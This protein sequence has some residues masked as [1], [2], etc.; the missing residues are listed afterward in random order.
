LLD[1]HRLL[2]PPL[3]RTNEIN[4]LPH[5][6][7]G[8]R[9]A[10]GWCDAISPLNG[11]RVRAS[12]WA[13]LTAKR[14]PAD[15]VVLAHAG[16]DGDWKIFVIS[17]QVV[18]RRDVADSLGTDE[19]L[20]SGWFA[21]FPRAAVPPGSQISAWGFDAESVRL[22]RLRQNVPELTLAPGG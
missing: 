5:T 21:T 20:W 19:Q 17:D 12:G 10:D 2:R 1:S 11:E 18:P 7:G 3:I 22:Y 13:A 8:S 15:A 16:G 14:R 6:P 9:S 4:A